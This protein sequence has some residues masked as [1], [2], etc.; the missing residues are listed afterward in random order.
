MVFRTETVRA[1]CAV[2]T[3]SL[4]TIQV[5]FVFKGRNN[6]I[7]SDCLQSSAYID[8]YCIQAYKED[9]KQR[10]V[11][12]NSTLTSVITFPSLVTSKLFHTCYGTKKSYNLPYILESNPHPFYS[13]R[14]L[15]NQMRIRIACELV[16]R[17]RIGFWKNDRAAVRAVR[18]IQ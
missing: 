8:T 12:R 17:S 15:K 10:C 16:S 11:I 1:Y 6:V 13:F 3:E 14:G 9:N 18:T 4:T 2:R 5:H 7:F